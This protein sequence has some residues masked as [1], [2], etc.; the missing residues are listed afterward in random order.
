M[1]K[2]YLVLSDGRYFEGTRIGAQTDT[3]GELVFTTGVV[4]YQETLADPAFA[5]QIVL[6]TFPLIGN[7]GVIEPDAAGACAASGYVVRELCDAPSNFRCEGDLNSYLEKNGVPGIAGVDTRELT[8]IL[9]E[10]GSLIARICSAVPENMAEIA[11]SPAENMVEKVSCKQPVSVPSRGEEKF[12]VTVVDYGVSKDL[13]SALTARGCAVTLVPHDTAARTVM[14]TAPQG[15][16]LSGGP[17]DPAAN[18]GCIAEIAKLIGR[19]PMLG[20]GLGHQMA[21]LAMGGTT[22]KLKYGHRGANQPVKE[23]GGTRT[24]ITSQNH[25]YIVENEPAGSAVT[26]VNANDSTCEGLNYPGKNCFTVQFTP[27]GSG[28]AGT[29]FVYDRFISMMEGKSHA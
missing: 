14:E 20:V 24:Y 21:A 13:I 3:S 12:R 16:V 28:F 19:V 23:V 29:G 5:G 27:G 17:G 22:A 7:Y 2:A 10:E 11:C 8:R 25:G 9:R 6:Q 1:K 15:V 18:P 26:F 4:G